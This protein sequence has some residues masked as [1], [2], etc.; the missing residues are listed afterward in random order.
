MGYNLACILVFPFAQ[1]MGMGKFLIQFSYELS[2]VR[3]CAC[4]LCVCAYVLCVCACDLCLCVQKEDKIGSP[5]KPLSDLGAISYR[6]YWA[7]TLL[8]HILPPPGAAEGNASTSILELAKI[9]S[10]LPE[11]IIQTLQYIGVL[12][13]VAVS[14]STVPDPKVGDS[15]A[16]PGSTDTCWALVISS[17]QAQALIVKYL[18]HDP[19]AIAARAGQQDMEEIVILRP[20]CLQWAPLYVADPKKDRWSIWS[21]EQVGISRGVI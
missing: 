17:T 6:S 12:V 19:R 10:I 11:D 20:E 15:R 14:S 18:P 4:D 1:R 7:S 5:E 3:M 21:H 9:T 16:Y 8:L 2:K 13:P